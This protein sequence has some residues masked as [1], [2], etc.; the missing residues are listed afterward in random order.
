[1]EEAR[2]RQGVRPQKEAGGFTATL[3]N[4]KIA[5]MEQQELRGQ[6]LA[7]IRQEPVQ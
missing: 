1:M 6:V 5:Y 4:V 7:R 3:S 2:T